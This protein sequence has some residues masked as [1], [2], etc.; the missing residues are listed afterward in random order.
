ML[1]EERFQRI[2][3]ELNTEQKVY[4]AGL[5]NLL[6]V[7][8]D[9]VRRDI[10]EL[11]E[12]GLLKSVRGGAVPHAPGPHHFKDRMEYDN[13]QKSI[14]AQKALQFI[15]EGQVIIFDGGTS[16]MLLARLL[17]KDIR[18]TVVTNSFPIANI[19]E[20]HEHIEVLF[21]GGRLLKKSFVTIGNEC[22]KFIHQFRADLCFLGICSIH[23]ELGVTGPDYEESE[24]KRAMIQS[25]REVIAL[26]TVEKLGTAEA[27]YVC[28]TNQL[29]AIV[30]DQSDQQGTFKIYGDLGIKMV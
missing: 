24:V 15:S 17:P 27:Y 11:A 21:A 29:T 7:S 25:S 13:E 3:E 8:E 5:S 20:E 10:K 18:L 6:N 1:K 23:T 19:L 16:A 4:L 12:Q 22:I 2:L 14:I 26:A 9:T 28:P 30:T